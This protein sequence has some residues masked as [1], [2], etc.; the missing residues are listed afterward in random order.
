MYIIYIFSK[1]FSFFD[2]IFSDSGTCFPD[3]N[4][5]GPKNA[6]KQSHY[7]AE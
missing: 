6:D 5:G 3:S 2:G 1:Y 7:I 4:H